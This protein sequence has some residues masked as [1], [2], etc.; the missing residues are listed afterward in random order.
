MYTTQARVEAYLNRELTAN[1][2][3]SVDDVISYISEFIE[4]YTNRQWLPAVDEGEDDEATTRVFDG[5]GLKDLVVDDFVGL[6]EVRVL[7][8]QGEVFNTYTS[9][10]DW[11]TFPSNKNP[12]NTIRLRNYHLPRGSANIEVDAIWG[13]GTPPSG[14]IVVAT[15]LTGKF[16]LKN[17]SS[18]GSYK[19]ES[20]E[21]YSYELMTGA[22]ID[23]D[24][25]N[26]ISTLNVYKKFTL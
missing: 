10:T 17:T 5:N 26:L 23:S 12:K 14:V 3:E 11:I 21:G 2:A 24:T 16:Y 19:K 15:A 18:I 9:D 22:D 25:Q 13:S 4:K 6:D 1:E 7:D 8:S 20:I